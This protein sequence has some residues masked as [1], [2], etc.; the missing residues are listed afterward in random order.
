L[1]LSGDGRINM[2]INNKTKVMPTPTLNRRL[3]V[4]RLEQE[5]WVNEGG[6]KHD[7]Y[8]HPAIKV[9]ITVPRHKE[10]SPGVARSIGKAAGW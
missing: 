7:L 9:V 4:Q 5:G 10:L 8:R 3:I 2:R 1:K 6:S